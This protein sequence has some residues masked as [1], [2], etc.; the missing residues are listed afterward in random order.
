[1]K[2]RSQSPSTPSHCIY[3]PILPLNAPIRLSCIGRKLFRH[4]RARI[5]KAD[6]KGSI[7]LFDMAW[8]YSGYARLQNETV[9]RLPVRPASSFVDK[10]PSV[11]SVSGF[12]LSAL[13]TAQAVLGYGLKSPVRR[14]DEMGNSATCNNPQLSCHNSSTVQDLCCF[15]SPG[16]ALLQTQ[17][18]DTDPAT[19]PN[20]SWTIHGLWVCPHIHFVSGLKH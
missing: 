18:W 12:A 1:M 17:F 13:G 19:G 3:P 20:D 5:R 16:G 10:M 4:A 14:Q 11:R 15:N 6:W 9:A 7:V 2:G 8:Y